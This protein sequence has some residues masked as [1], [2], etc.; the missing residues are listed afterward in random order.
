MIRMTDPIRIVVCSDIHFGCLSND[1]EEMAEAFVKTIF[2]LLP[3]TDMFHINGDL[4]DDVLHFDRN[5]FDPIYITFMALFNECAKHN[6]IFRLN[7]GT[8]SHDRNQCKRIASF[9]N[10]TFYGQFDFKFMDGIHFETVTIKGR[11]LRFLYVRDD[12]PYKSAEDAVD[13][14]RAKMAELGWDYVDYAF[15]H[16][17]FEF[18]FPNNVSREKRVVFTRNQF[19]FV[20]KVIDAGH[21]HQ[22][23]V[24]GNAISNGSFDRMSFGDEDPKGCIQILD[25]PDHYV[26]KFIENRFAAVY[27]TIEISPEE[28]THQIRDKIQAHIAGLNTTRKISLRFLVKSQEQYH[29]IVTWMRETYPEIRI[30]SKREKDKTE[31]DIPNRST[32][33]VESEVKPAPTPETLSVYVLSYIDE[34]FPNE[35][36]PITIDK[37]NTYIWQNAA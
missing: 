9:Y 7:Q 28:D 27:D 30:S 22:Y 4:F 35:E 32:L 10:S 17:F 14:I 6:V 37:I 18:T 25:Y 13:A 23:R 19:S 3:E 24:D 34:H 16:G 26:A 31:V 5:E 8:Y 12:L 21:V 2:P 33:L 15:V 1:Q 36:Q 29:A 11:D 20:R